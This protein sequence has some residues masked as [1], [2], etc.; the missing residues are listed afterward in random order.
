MRLGEWLDSKGVKQAA[1][2]RRIGS[3][4]ATVHRIVAGTQNIPLSLQDAIIRETDGEVTA[5]D[6]HAAYAE[7]RE[8]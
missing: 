3:T 1:F 5:S 2:A 6:L 8:Q 7:A 4:S